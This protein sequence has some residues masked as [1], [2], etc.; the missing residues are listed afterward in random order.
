MLIGPHTF[1]D[2]AFKHFEYAA[3]P[4]RSLPTTPHGCLCASKALLFLFLLNTSKGTD[5]V[6]QQYFR[7]H[8]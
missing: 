2:F 1:R 6:V 7:N 5:D 8:W 4:Q 3:P